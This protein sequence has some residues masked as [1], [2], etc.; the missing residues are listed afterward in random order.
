M[1]LRHTRSAPRHRMPLLA[2]AGVCGLLFALVGTAVHPGPGD[3]GQRAEAGEGEAST[4]KRDDGYAG[5]EACQRCHQREYDLWKTSSHYHTVES[6]REDNVPGA[7]LAEE[8]ATH[9]PGKSTFRQAGDKFFVSTVGEDGEVHEYPLTH[10]VG[11]MRVRMYMT[12]MPDGRMQVLPG[13]MEAQTE[14]WFDYTKLIFGAGGTD[15]DKAPVVKPGDLS[16]WSGSVRSWDNRCARCHTS[17]FEAVPPAKPGEVKPHHTARRIGIDC[18]SCHGPSASHVEFHNRRESGKPV[19]G[20]DPILALAGLAPR[21]H[22]SICMQCHMEGDLVDTKYE[23]G[24]DIFEHLDPTLIVDPERLDPYGRQLELV[25]DGVPFHS[26]RCVQE[27]GLT[28]ATCHDPHGSSSRSQ[29]RKSASNADLCASCHQEIANNL[30]AH[31]HHDP[32]GSGS[33]CV[34]CHMPFLRIERGHGVVADHA[35]SIPRLDL[36]GDRVAQDACT[37]CHTAGLYAPDDAPK[38]THDQLKVAYDK[39]WPGGGKPASWMEALASARLEEEGATTKLVNVL[40][41]KE[42]PRVVRGSA[43]ELLGRHAK[44]L[45]LAI[46]ARTRD[47]DSLVRR[48]AVSALAELDGPV[49]DGLLLTAMKDTSLSVRIAAARA[50][51]KGWKRIQKNKEL[52]AAAISILRADANEVMEDWIRWWLLAGA[53]DLAGNKQGALEAYERV[54]LLDRFATNVRKRIKQLREELKK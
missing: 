25:Y 22:T 37:W 28:C 34:S 4:T 18:E 29:L 43:M 8:T 10:V 17:G 24:N 45:P 6:I 2:M 16:F 23:I 36:K 53:E 3:V 14:K 1:Q 27:G 46:I 5:A 13:M 48:R 7:V 32:K 44:E 39:W 31:T 50:S 42:L 21:R 47:P 52:R 15:W 20:E 35:I 12:T 40:R 11:R 19:K 30:E 54:A 26:S 49:V 33:S 51:V 41:D 38:Q 9:P